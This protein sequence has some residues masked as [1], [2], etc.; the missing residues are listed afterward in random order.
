MVHALARLFRISISR[1]HEL[2]PIAR[3]LEH[4]APRRAVGEAPR[5]PLEVLHSRGQVPQG[6]A[7][8]LG[9]EPAGQHSIGQ[10]GY[11]F[12]MDRAGDIVYHP[13]QQLLTIWPKELESSRT[14]RVPP[15]GR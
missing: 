1:G 6:T 7:Q 10:R 2:I 14:S 4:G 11:C 3:E 9:Q 8:Q 5:V 13:Q 12:L 15:G